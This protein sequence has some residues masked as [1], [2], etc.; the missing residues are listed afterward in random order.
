[1]RPIRAIVAAAVALFA[2]LSVAC[3]TRAA[4]YRHSHLQANLCGNA[5]NNG[6]A[7]VVTDLVNSIQSREPHTVTLNEV[8]ENQYNRLR[9]DLPDYEGEFDPTGAVCHNGA[10][11]GNAILARTGLTVVGSWELPNPAGDELRRLMCLS[12]Q[13]YEGLP[14][15]ICV[16]HISNESGNI[17]AQVSTVASILSGLEVPGALMVGGDFNANPHDVRM[18]PMY[19]T[20]YDAGA[21]T[22]REA[23]SG[24]EC[25]DRSTINLI[26]GSDVINEDTYARHK[27][28]YIFLLDGH[29]SSADAE[30]IAMDFS[31]HDALWA[32][33]QTPPR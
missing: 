26:V 5:C 3:D 32:T 29:W 20:C 1:M 12:T 7:P 6:G 22:F 30:A 17:A 10:R 4:E 15:V 28:D 19:S 25:T 2:T 31:D 18:N 24:D 27:F 9:A 21:G 13:P 11:Y 8:C 23:D 33:A 14:L 16:T